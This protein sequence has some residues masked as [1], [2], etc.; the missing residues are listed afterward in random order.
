MA[1]ELVSVI[2]PCY[3]GALYIA[4][5]IESVRNQTYP[6]WE[7]L[8]VD[9]CS[10]DNSAVI[11]QKYCQLDR[12]VKYFKTD[13]A[14]GSPAIP[15]NMAMDRAQGRY[16]AFLDCDDVWLPGKL[17]EQIVCQQNT[18]AAIVFSNYEKMSSKGIR[19]RR[20]VIAPSKIGYGEMYYGNPIGCLT[21]F[22]DTY[23]TG[24]FYFVNSHHE[25]YIAWLSLIRLYG[26][27]I[28]TNTVTACYRESC[29][30]VTSNK[31]KI[32]TWQWNIYRK[33]LKLNFVMAG[34]YY[35]HYAFRAF[36]KFLI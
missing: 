29:D 12:R 31:W 18:N 27:A 4:Q 36:K 17:E 32:L 14:S 11:I 7:I 6:H 13:K 23:I 3:N 30:S 24:K 28:N 33:I 26:P 1:K 9:D 21:V 2:I 8:A 16:L 15:R 22:I 10:T 20:I 35:L 19:S 25:D 34:Y 5:C